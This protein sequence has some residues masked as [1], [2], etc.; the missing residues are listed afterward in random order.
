[1]FDIVKS[2]CDLRV[3]AVNRSKILFMIRVE[4]F[5]GP[6]ILTSKSD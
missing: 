3:L 4:D 2:C 1:M 5:N 6:E